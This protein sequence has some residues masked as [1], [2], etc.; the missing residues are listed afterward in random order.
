[1][2]QGVY[3]RRVEEVWSTI[4]VAECSKP[5]G[6]SVGSLL[7]Q[8]RS[9]QIWMPP[10]STTGC[11]HGTDDSIHDSIKIVTP[12]SRFYFGRVGGTTGSALDQQS[13]NDRKVVGSRPTKVVCV[14][15]CWQVTAWGELSAVAG[16]HSFFRAVGSWSLD[17]QHLMDLDLA[18]VNGKSGRQSW[19]CWRFPAL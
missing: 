13:T 8:G 7:A 5:Q 4:H 1:V 19:H 14:S 16:R 10:V 9:V 6:W 2:G 17:C 11:E 3:G 15:Q 12:D 18:W